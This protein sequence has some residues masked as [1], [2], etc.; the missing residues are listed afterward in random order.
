[1][2]LNWF[3]T[4]AD[5]GPPPIFA[6]LLIETPGGP[7]YRVNVEE[8]GW[9]A[10]TQPMLAIASRVGLILRD[11]KTPSVWLTPQNG[12]GVEYLSR[13]I[14]AL[15]MQGSDHKQMRVAGLLCGDQAVWLHSDGLV[16][17]QPEPTAWR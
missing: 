1:M 14:G 16:E 11:S 3:K 12:H 5:A 9:L 7:T 10:E 6:D 8:Q 13:V 4:N 17:V 15:S 2:R